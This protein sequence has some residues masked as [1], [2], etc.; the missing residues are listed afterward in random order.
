MGRLLSL[1][2]IAALCCGVSLAVPAKRGTYTH[3]QRDGSTVT[4]RM[5]GDAFHH[6]WVSTT[7]GRVM[8]RDA[9]GD[10]YY[11]DESE[12][13]AR[14]ARAK[15]R[16]GAPRRVGTHEMPVS[17]TP[18]IPVLL[19]QY[20]DIKFKSNH[21]KSAFTNGYVTGDKSVQQ[22]F[23]DQSNTQY[24]PQF[25]VFGPYTL[26]KNRSEYGGNSGGRDKGVGA[27]VAEAV[28][29]AT[30]VNFG[31]YDN[32]GNGNCDVVIVLYAG[33][34]E[35]QAY[36]I[37]PN[38]VWPCQW[39]L[40]SANYYGDGPGSFEQNGKTIN[41][42]AV[43]NELNGSSDNTTKL[44]GIGT[45]CHEFSHCLG[46]PDF[47]ET[48]T[49]EQGYYGMGSW[50]LMD[51]GCYNDDG[52]TP[53]GYSAYEKEFMGWLSYTTPVANTKYTLP[54]LNSGND[55]AVKVTSPLNSNEYYILENRAQQGWDE[56]IP[57]EGMMVT[58]VTY[59]ESRWQDNS[60]NNESIQLCTIIP[61]DNSLSSASETN[62]LWPYGSHTELTNTSTPAAKLYMK[63]SGSLSANAGTMD[64]PLTE[65]TR[66]S[67]G[68][69]SF[70]YMRGEV[71]AL[72]APTLG[73]ATNVKG[74]EF[75]ANWSDANT[76]SHTY[77]L[78]V[79]K[80]Q[81]AVSL[82]SEDFSSMDFTESTSTDI[83]TKLDNYT[84]TAGWTGSKV[85]PYEGYVQ[86]G[87]SNA[88][89]YIT[90]P[91]LD[92][93]DSGGKVT[94]KF[95]AAYNDRNS[96]LKVSLG[97]TDVTQSLTATAADYT[98]VLDCTAATG[99]TI[100][101]STTGNRKRVK[102]YNVEILA[103]DAS[104][105][106]PRRAVAE[107]G[108]ADSRTITGITTKSYT[109]TGLTPG[110]TY[111]YKVKAVPVSEEEALESDWSATKQVAL[112][113]PD[114]VIIT[115]LSEDALDF[116][117]ITLG[118]GAVSQTL[119]V[120]A[121]DLKADVTLA[122]ADESNSFAIDVTTIAQAD[123]EEGAEV[124]VTYDPQTYGSHTAT[125]TI[126]ST[127]AEPV[128]VTLTGVAELEKEVPVLDE[129]DESGVNASAFRASWGTVANVSSYTLQVDVKQDTPEPVVELLL[130]E[131]FS[132]PANTTWAKSATGTYNET[133]E[134]Y[135]RL[136][137]T[138]LVGSITSPAVNLT[139]SNGLATVIV[140]AKSYGND[141][142]V[143][144][145]VSIIDDDENVVDSEIITL[146]NSDADYEIVLTGNASNNNHVRIES[147][148]ARKRVMLKEAKVY[149]GDATAAGAPRRATETG[150]ETTRT[151]T[152][153]T[154]NYYEVNDLASETTYTYKVKAVYIDGT[155]SE[156]SAANEVTTKAV[157]T[158]VSDVAI[159]ADVT[160]VRY[161][162]VHGQQIARPQ[163]GVN[164]VVT[165]YAD[166]S[167]KALKVVY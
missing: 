164:I 156:W 118:S 23:S 89:G 105:Q 47:Y 33:V 158:G 147:L 90:T 161:Y 130:D 167:Q 31:N 42:F 35:A 38:A 69:V 125:L 54:Q 150:D 27:M 74:S 162:N 26:S 4:V 28:Q 111:D 50:S 142:N 94:V 166:G 16:R 6:Q 51:Y 107:T 76:I 21:G 123:A 141:A 9:N 106:A 154:E 117:T 73:E 44:D 83:G 87:S 149:S 159:V 119:G 46:L 61:A 14:K 102:L 13:A 84:A 136:G 55:M 39:D 109:V 37:V 49:Y 103:G 128:V 95:R 137:T 11:L 135:L 32:D 140:T 15:M 29:M 116:G 124:V 93:S 1:L 43:F 131:D 113:D 145:K 134:G 98:L 152:G 139:A 160:E 78:Q 163:Q 112:G 127:D 101:L 132:V 148:A 80:H 121:S 5:V 143:E 86:L 18:R 97:N 60:V 68:T 3:T 70:W 165:R 151:I 45:F 108:D 81:D 56:F 7:D 62:D 8:D 75:T 85:F 79:T 100:S 57:D 12:I 40:N 71:S 20:K 88:V 17:G 24:V 114:P 146:T 120:L 63:A 48:N 65:I 144:M 66:N 91:S 92:L 36:G 115:D 25:E 157:V 129:L 153:I 133:S 67:D 155:E 41:R 99:Q 110:A 22:Y 138:S 53:I 77:T 10:F 2:A 30:D 59:V 52:Y 82:V 58:H 126:S 19:V 64:Q 122:L 96:S 34:G 104:S 72:S